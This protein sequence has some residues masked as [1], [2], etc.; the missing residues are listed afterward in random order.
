MGSFHREC[1]L[2]VCARVG[3]HE[4]VGPSD[5]TSYDA[6]PKTFQWSSKP[7]ER[8]ISKSALVL[9]H[10]SRIRVDSLMNNIAVVLR[11]GV[12]AVAPLMCGIPVSSVN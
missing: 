5:D 8:V 2:T 12:C 6:H 10:H 11:S 7:Q 1:D 9:L 4:C 3:N